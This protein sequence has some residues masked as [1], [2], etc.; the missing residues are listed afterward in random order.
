MEQRVMFICDYAAPYGGNFI[1]SLLEL[2]KKLNSKGYECIYI[3]TA[4]NGKRAWIDRLIS[5]GK[6]VKLCDLD[7]IF[8]YFKICD[9]TKKYNVKIIHLHFAKISLAMFLRCFSPVQKVVW[10]VHSDFSLGLNKKSIKSWIRYSICGKFVKIVSVSPKL[11]NEMKNVM[12]LPN[13]IVINRFDN[14]KFERKEERNKLGI[15]DNDKMILAFGWSPKVKG[16]DI[17]VKVLDLLI[18][19]DKNYKLCLVC[20]N[21][22]TID[23]MKRY[24]EEDLKQ[25]LSNIYLLNPIENI[26]LYHECSDIL[27]SASR[28]E[29]FSYTILEALCIG[30]KCVVSDIPGVA[31][32]KKYALVKIF[33]SENIKACAECIKIAEKTSVDKVKISKQVRADFSIDKWTKEIIENVY[34]L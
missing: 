24:I 5:M 31:W 30:N 32:S 11:S 27:L 4:R 8:E 12:Y 29:G 23:K 2:D 3:F 22:Y 34:E 16:V 17:A 9:L 20:G 33:E 28:S 6:L 10:H 7:S 18:K 21:E 19:E 1:A 13:G 15:E 14:S 26:F 25:N